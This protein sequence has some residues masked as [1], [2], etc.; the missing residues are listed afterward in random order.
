M[1][2][3]LAKVIPLG[4]ASALSPGILALVVYFLS[5][6]NAKSKILAMFFSALLV[7]A[8]VITLGL[9]AGSSTPWADGQ[10]LLEAIIDLLFGVLFIYFA[11]K[12]LLRKERTIKESQEKE[13]SQFMKWFLIGCLI[14]ATNFDA[15]FLAFTSAKEIGS[16]AVNIFDKIIA[17][18]INVLFFTSPVTLPVAIYLLMPK[19]AEVILSKINKILMRYSKYIVFAMFAIFGV[20]FLYR[21]IK[22]FI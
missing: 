10:S 9:L 17:V 20:I 8:I 12:N 14:N 15:V 2:A 6:K 7:I 5:N 22:Y 19:T 16:S 1:I 18:I 11:L 21:G 13:G 4:F 3:L